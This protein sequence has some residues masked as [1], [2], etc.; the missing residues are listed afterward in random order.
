[1]LTVGLDFS[2]HFKIQRC[3]P[4]TQSRCSATSGHTASDANQA[5]WKTLTSSRRQPH[6]DQQRLPDIGYVLSQRKAAEPVKLRKA[7]FSC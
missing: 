2:K 3:P 7:S 1:M 4:L 5:L 6:P